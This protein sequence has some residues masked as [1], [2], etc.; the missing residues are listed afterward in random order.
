MIGRDCRVATRRTH[1]WSRT[2]D[3]STVVG[4]HPVLQACR[5]AQALVMAYLNVCSASSLK[6]RYLA[7][8]LCLV[9]ALS[10]DLGEGEFAQRLLKAFTSC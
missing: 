8:L 7:A 4:L 9:K 10:T 2:W 3:E 1:S 5:V 6:Q